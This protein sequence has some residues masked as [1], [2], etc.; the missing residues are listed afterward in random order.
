MEFPAEVEAHRRV[1]VK[2]V[3]ALV[4]RQTTRRKVIVKRANKKA[5]DSWL[6]RRNQD[7]EATLKT[8]SRSTLHRRKVE[9]VQRQGKSP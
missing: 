8:L 7:K 9:K 2:A 6:H 3:S 1:Q 5:P 4:D